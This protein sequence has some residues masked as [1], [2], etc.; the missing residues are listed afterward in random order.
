MKSVNNLADKANRKMQLALEE[1]YNNLHSLEVI[2]T[3]VSLHVTV[4]K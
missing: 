4:V 3:F 1:S 2:T